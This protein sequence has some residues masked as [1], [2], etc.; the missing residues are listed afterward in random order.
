MCVDVSAMQPQNYPTHCQPSFISKFQQQDNCALVHSQ[1]TCQ[2]GNGAE[3]HSLLIVCYCAEVPGQRPSLP[4]S[5]TEEQ[6]EEET[7]HP[8]SC[9]LAHQIISLCESLDAR[10][11]APVLFCSCGPQFS[12]VLLITK[13]TKQGRYKIQHKLTM[14]TLLVSVGDTVLSSSSLSPPLHFIILSP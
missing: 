2:S 9:E 1:S 3:T 13:V 6:Q 7:T 5:T 12:D 8:V 11:V 10:L 14:K 4:G